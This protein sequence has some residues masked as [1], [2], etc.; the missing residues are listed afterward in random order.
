MNR[1]GSGE[2]R[3]GMNFTMTLAPVSSSPQASYPALRGIPRSRLPLTVERS[4]EEREEIAM[5]WSLI[6]R[7]VAAGALI[8]MVACGQQAGAPTQTES[9]S[10]PTFESEDFS[11]PVT[12]SVPEDWVA[13]ET[14]EAVVIA[15]PLEDGVSAER[16]VMFRTEGGSPP[17]EVFSGFEEGG[18][19]E[20]RPIGEPW[21]TDLESWLASI[22]MFEVVA[23]ESAT[24]A[25]A[26]VTILEA[27]SDY[28]PPSARP[29][30]SLRFILV[31]SAEGTDVI[32]QTGEML[33]RFV[34]F[35]DRPLALAYGASANDFSEEHYMLIVDSLRFDESD[36]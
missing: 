2:C 1:G 9:P 26:P 16:M 28:E 21:P 12:V 22:E 30:E 17:V 27:R 4:M 19:E 36:S 29:A 31:G 25:D 20:G 34:L 10:S 24:V 11:W 8:G 23:T 6:K 5:P 35:E 14:R 13:Y 32:A 18:A 3:R 15:G 33:W 7:G